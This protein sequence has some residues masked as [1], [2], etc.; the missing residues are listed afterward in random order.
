MIVHLTMGSRPL[1]GA[2]GRREMVAGEWRYA[3]ASPHVSRANCADC[4]RA[5][6]GALNAR[7]RQLGRVPALLDADSMGDAA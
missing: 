2:K 5:G 7:Q 6:L 3:D 4:I 1:C